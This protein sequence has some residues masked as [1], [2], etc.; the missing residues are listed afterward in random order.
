MKKTS[1]E[2]TEGYVY[3]S[4]GAV[5][6]S[7]FYSWHVILSKSNQSPLYLFYIVSRNVYK[8]QKT[9]CQSKFR[10]FVLIWL[11][12]MVITTGQLGNEYRTMFL[13]SAI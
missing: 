7:A 2:V 8:P 5:T 4:S 10:C 12:F 11:L 3:S 1:H 9:V 6:I 13:H